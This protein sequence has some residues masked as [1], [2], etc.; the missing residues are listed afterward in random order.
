MIKK[1]NTREFYKRRRICL[2]VFIIIK[3][4][5]PTA[6]AKDELLDQAKAILESYY[7]NKLPGEVYKATSITEMLNYLKDPYTQYYDRDNV[8]VFLNI[9]NMK[10]TGI[11]VISESIDMGVRVLSV[12]PDS[13][14][15]VAGIEEGDIILSVN[16][17]QLKGLEH[18]K[19]AE[20][21]NGTEGSILEL[22]VIRKGEM[23]KF[24]LAPE[25]I[26]Y[27]TITFEIINENIGYI[28][29]SSFGNLTCKE[30]NN[31]LSI[32]KRKGVHN[33]ILDLRNNPGGFIK[34]AADIA[35]FFIGDRVVMEVQ[36][37][38]YGRTAIRSERH[39]EE[40]TEP[41]V[42]LINGGSASAAEIFAA[43]L[44]DYKKAVLI[45]NS[46][47]GKGVAQSI[48][49]LKDGS[50]LKA[51]TLRFYSPLGVAI[52]GKGVMPDL[53]T[54]KLD[55]KLVG[56]VFLEDFNKYSSEGRYVEHLIGG[57]R[58][59]FNIENLNTELKWECYRQIINNSSN[60][61]TNI[62]CDERTNKDFN[63]GR[64]PKI[65][66]VE[67]PK[68]V[69]RVGER[70]KFKLSAGLYT[71]KVEYRCTLYDETENKYIDL[72]E[73]SDKYYDKWKP[74]GGEVFTVGFPINKPGNYRISF[75]VKRANIGKENTALI[76][77]ECDSYVEE[78]P[79]IIVE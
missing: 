17:D 79:I 7:I 16:S 22:E 45:G 74:S 12:L 77:R 18:S 68:T 44:R 8:E 38:L 57:H 61:Y 52:D 24:K 5:S 21:L 33:Y 49:K 43:A 54:S 41:V 19:A 64:L 69:Y 35:G 27:P 71:G 10:Y 25:I 72:W 14:A 59:S 3:L 20:L 67:I 42:V 32:L 4:L 56:Q 75:Y 63:M 76:T 47:Y 26:P 15:N 51:T 1:C 28:R 30:F 70:V 58:V 34:V 36:D 31:A 39:E 65:Q 11:G 37:K 2:I 29:I 50:M 60:I 73:T 6:R 53:V 23:V 40:L 78:I 9:L 55:A 48:F 46:T 13:P 66:Y 62:N